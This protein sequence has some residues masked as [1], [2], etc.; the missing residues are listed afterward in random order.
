MG[1]AEGRRFGVVPTTP[2]TLA[3]RPPRSG[4]FKIASKVLRKRGSDFD[5]QVNLHQQSP[6]AYLPP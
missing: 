6:E 1:R 4:L 2:P 5:T 3:V